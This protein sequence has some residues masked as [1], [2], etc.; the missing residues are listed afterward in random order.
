MAVM[1]L[2]RFLAGD[3]EPLSTGKHRQ[4]GNK[5]GCLGPVAIWGI[6]NNPPLNPTK[7][8]REQL[9]PEPTEDGILALNVS[10]FVFISRDQRAPVC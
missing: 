1:V 7:C 8:I 2:K 5:I 9:L 10:A 3:V 6:V 4:E